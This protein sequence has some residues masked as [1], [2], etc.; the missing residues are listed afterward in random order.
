[1]AFF[2]SLL[3]NLLIFLLSAILIGYVYFTWHFGYWK[4][5][6]I[7]FIPPV[8]V[9]GNF[10]SWAML[11]TDIGGMFREIYQK[12][13]GNESGIVGIW[14]FRK[15]ALVVTSPEMIKAI[16]VKDFNHFADRSAQADKEYDPLGADNLFFGKN[17]H[18]KLMRVKLT[19]LFSSA[20]MKNM[21]GLMNEIGKDLETCIAEHG[22]EPVEV[23]DTCARFT[24]DV[25]ATT[26]YGLK[27]NALLDKQ[28]PFNVF[29]KKLLDFRWFRS[30][31]FMSIFFMQ[32]FAKWRK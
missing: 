12:A 5:K 31:E 27:A 30:V 14:V 8:P 13:K 22:S 29:R 28:A 25:I 2:L 17:P 19:H 9:L 6:N 4:K 18:W 32:G 16:L 11:R 23:R 1:M 3:L 7:P 10:G 26:A 21:F 15:P 20:K 24:T